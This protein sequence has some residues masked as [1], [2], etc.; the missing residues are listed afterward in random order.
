M[1]QKAVPE[2]GTGAAGIASDPAGSG[3][4]LRSNV[5]VIFSQ[6][7][8]NTMFTL[9]AFY[10]IFTLGHNTTNIRNLVNAQGRSL[11]CRY[12]VSVLA[13]NIKPEDD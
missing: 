3:R 2:G 11:V 8:D 10:G 7:I 9:I 6:L 4:W 12:S 13:R 1:Y 5:S